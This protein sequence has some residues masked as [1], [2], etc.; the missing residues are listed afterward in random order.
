MNDLRLYLLI[1]GLVLLA[2]IY[3]WGTLNARNKQRQQT[4][5]QHSSA[6]EL[7]NLKIKSSP[8]TEIDYSS[9]LTCLNQSISESKQTQTGPLIQNTVNDDAVPQQQ[10]DKGA[11]PESLEAS[12][13]PVN[14]AMTTASQKPQLVTLYVI[15]RGD[16]LFNG[17]SILRVMN[18]LDLQFGAM[19]IFH[20]YGIGE[21]KLDDAL[22]S[23]ANM[24]EPGSFDMN[25]IES[26][27][28]HGLVMFMRVPATI[29]EQ[30]VFELMLNTAQRMSELLGADVCDENRSL[31]SDQKI[32]SIRNQLVN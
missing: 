25:Q 21:I 5:Q 32:E 29:D 7:G 30:V 10:Q 20:H 18:E 23:V 15:P 27:N 2:G 13:E 26:F 9:V 14:D 17:Q 6:D 16:G 24:M 28:S 1:I 22:F 19:N 8:E 3:I 11:A 4:I 31:I 12:S